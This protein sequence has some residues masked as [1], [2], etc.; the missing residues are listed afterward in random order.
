MEALNLASDDGMLNLV[1]GGLLNL[2]DYW[3]VIFLVWAR[4][5]VMVCGW[6]EG[7]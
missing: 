4:W 1:D 6:F 7:L 3:V 5:W 2:A